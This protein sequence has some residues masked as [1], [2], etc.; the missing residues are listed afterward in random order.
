M[1][2]AKARLAAGH[3]IDWQD[4]VSRFTLD[5]A[6]AFLFGADVR[7]LDAGLAYAPHSPEA[8]AQSNGMFNVTHYIYP[9]ILTE[10]TQRQSTRHTHSRAR[11]SPRRRA[12][13]GAG[14]TAACGRCTSSGRTG[15]R[16]ICTRLRGSLRR[17]WRMRWRG[18]GRVVAGAA[19]INL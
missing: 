17:L 3:A 4:L 9:R 10:K 8:Q 18:S 2:L 12:R 11:S 19:L 1:S 16:S 7:S 14:G 13:R 6:T 15:W 5:C